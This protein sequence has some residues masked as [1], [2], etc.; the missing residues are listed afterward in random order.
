MVARL[1]QALK[2]TDVLPRLAHIQSSFD[3]LDIEGLAVRVRDD[4]ALDLLDATDLTALGAPPSLKEYDEACQLF[5]TSSKDWA[6]HLSTR[7]LIAGYLLSA[8]FKDCSFFVR[9][10]PTT[11][12]IRLVDLDVKPLGRLGHYAQLDR[13]IWRYALQ[14]PPPLRACT[15]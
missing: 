1:L 7:Q 12:V 2:P 15:S 14:H 8:T 6:T 5:T 3:P 4:C 13:K 10:S 9:F 11:S